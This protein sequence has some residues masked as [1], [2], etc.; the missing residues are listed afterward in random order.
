MTQLE[1]LLNHFRKG[2]T[3]TVLQAHREGICS[4]SK[5][6]CELKEAGHAIKGP[7]VPVK[8]RFGRKVKVARYGL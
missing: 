6:V 4:L 7:R 8:S 1:W 5:R 2:R 3:I